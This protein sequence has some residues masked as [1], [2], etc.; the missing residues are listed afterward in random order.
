MRIHGSARSFAVAL[1]AWAGI[2]SAQIAPAD[3]VAAG[4][5]W[6]DALVDNKGAPV[7][8][9]AQFIAVRRPEI[10]HDLEENIYGRTPAES[11]TEDFQVTSVDPH[12]LG[13]AA[14][15]KQIT[16]AFRSGSVYRL[17]GVEGLP[18]HARYEAGR[19]QGK[20]LH[21]Y[22]RPGGHDILLADWKRYIEFA[23]EHFHAGNH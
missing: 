7:T 20:T 1:M 19:A 18:A 11:V 4:A 21:Y 17:F 12:P 14:V 22:L 16:I 3:K 9:A 23:N 5:A 13:G 2:C 6:P 15:R 8:T 10:L